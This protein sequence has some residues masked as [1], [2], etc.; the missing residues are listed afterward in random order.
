MEVYRAECAEILRRYR[1]G[2]ITYTQCVDALASAV[3]AAV[4]TVPPDKMEL[5]QST[6]A[7]NSAALENMRTGKAN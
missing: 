7:A 4:P 3:S 6:V 1:I 2:R 5:L